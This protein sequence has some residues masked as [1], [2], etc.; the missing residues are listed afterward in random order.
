MITTNITYRPEGNVCMMAFL[1]VYMCFCFAVF[2][3]CDHWLLYLPECGRETFSDDPFAVSPSLRLIPI[4]PPI[5]NYEIDLMSPSPLNIYI[6]K[7]TMSSTMWTKQPH[8]HGQNRSDPVHRLLMCCCSF[9]F[10][11]FWV[12]FNIC[13]NFSAWYNYF[14]FDLSLIFVPCV[15]FVDWSDL[16]F[17]LCLC[18]STTHFYFVVSFFSRFYDSV[19]VVVVVIFHMSSLSPTTTT[20]LNVV[21]AICCCY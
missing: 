6:N 10:L 7:H 9:F 14:V 20:T 1:C 16:L 2:V 4:Q 11:S 5:S 3:M 21:L 19:V 13:D 17:D 8:K 12:S 18:F 15:N